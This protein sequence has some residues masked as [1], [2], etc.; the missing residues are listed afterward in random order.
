MESDVAFRRRRAAQERHLAQQATNPT[1]RHVHDVMADLYEQGVR[2][3]G[4][5]DQQENA[6]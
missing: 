6:A 1:V 2:N 5:A 3:A 4:R